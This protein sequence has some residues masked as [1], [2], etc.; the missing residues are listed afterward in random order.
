MP[1]LNIAPAIVEIEFVQSSQTLNFVLDDATKGVLDNT[2][3]KLGGA[4]WTDVTSS[5]YSTTIQR[6]KNQALA[7]YNAGTLSVVLDNQTAQFDPTIPAGTSGYPY[8]GQII[9]GKRVRVTVGTELQFLGVVQDWDLDYPL[10]GIA[11]ASLRA[12]DAFVQLANRTLEADTFTTALSSSMLTSVLDQPEVAFDSAYRD[13]QTGVTTLQ[14]TTVTL[15]T[16]ALTFC[17]LIESSEPGSLFVSKEGFLTFRSRRYNPTYSGAIIITD[18]GTSVTPRSIEVEYGSELLYNRATITRAGGTTQV[19]NDAD[20]QTIY[21]ILAY[22]QSGLLMNSDAV[23]LSMAQYYAN[24][25]GEPVFR[26][27]RVK[28]DM[29][30]QTGNDQGLLQALDLDDLVLISFTPPGGQLI[31]RYMVVGGISHRVTPGRHE[32]DLDLLDADDQGMTYGTAA[33]SPEDQ[34]LSLLDSNRYGF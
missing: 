18:D 19:A 7:R 1:G 28:L 17:Q 8:A 21:G 5:A 20:S 31:E 29:M 13:I 22:D 14:T 34:P 2:T 6:G 4:T 10:G 9:P 27:K 11:T 32:I 30:A 12:A 26:P 23:A 16:N 33:L 25:Y 15:G 24:T 3:Y